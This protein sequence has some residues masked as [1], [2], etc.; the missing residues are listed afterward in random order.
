MDLRANGPWDESEV[1]LA[2]GVQRLDLGALR[3]TPTDGVD[4]Q[5]QVDEASGSV[6]Q[7]SFARRDGMVQVQPYAAPRSG[8]LWADVRS[9]RSSRR[10]TSPVDW[11]RRRKAPSARS[12]AHR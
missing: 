11:S 1:D 8:G 7:L 10:S 2:D 6:S 5:V 12:C 3:V 4:V 9:R